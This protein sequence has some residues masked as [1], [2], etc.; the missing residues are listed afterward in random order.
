[1]CVLVKVWQCLCIT[2]SVCHFFSSLI[3]WHRETK[4]PPSIRSKTH[5]KIYNFTEFGT[6]LLFTTCGVCHIHSSTRSECARGT[7]RMTGMHGL[8]MA[9][10][11]SLHFVLL[12][13]TKTTIFTWKTD[14]LILLYIHNDIK[15]LTYLLTYC[16]TAKFLPPQNISIWLFQFYS[17]FL[18]RE[19]ACYL[20]DAAT[21]QWGQ[22]SEKAETIWTIFSKRCKLT[23]L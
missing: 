4:M 19:L 13:L 22:H 21:P 15:T 23:C 5:W 7:R 12:K 11:T 17:N 10:P 3:Y 1:M 6:W 8:K 14:W 20:V 16:H 2:L 18:S 9:D